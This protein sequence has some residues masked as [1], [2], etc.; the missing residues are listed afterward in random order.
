MNQTLAY[1]GMR[2]LGA[3]A[4]MLAGSLL[5]FLV[6]KAAPGDPAMI[7]LG[8]FATPEAMAAFNAER[9]LDQPVLAQYGAW[10]ARIVQLDFGESLTVA[11]GQRISDLLLLRLPNT[12]FIGVLAVLIAL[13]ISLAV[14]ISAAIWRGTAIDTAEIG[15]AHV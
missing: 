2:G 4:T 6:M 13:A 10:L 9:R 8:D 14:G 1:L 5:V 12:F 15:R 3:L 11:G 7:A